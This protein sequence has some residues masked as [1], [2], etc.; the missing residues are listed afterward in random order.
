KGSTAVDAGSGART[1]VMMSTAKGNSIT[2]L[3]TNLPVEP[4][5][6]AD[7]MKQLEHAV[8]NVARGLA[9]MHD[10][11]ASGVQSE[12]QKTT[13]AGFIIRKLDA[14]KGVLGS[15][16]YARIKAI[17]QGDVLPKYVASKVPATAYHGDANT[18]NFM[19]DG[20]GKVS[21]IDLDTMK[22]S[23]ENSDP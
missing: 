10:S 9:E 18:G 15:G 17:L 7:A 1:G 22:Y 19:V 11:F 3:C 6:R 23:F 14:I 4:A 16:R 20:Q 12:A 13:D 5:P 8:K 2:D 21:T